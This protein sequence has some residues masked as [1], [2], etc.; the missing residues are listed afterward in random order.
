MF[1]VTTTLVGFLSKSG[2]PYSFDSL[3]TINVFFS[4]WVLLQILSASKTSMNC[5]RKSFQTRQTALPHVVGSNSATLA[6]LT[7]WQRS[8]VKNGLWILIGF[9]TWR[10][11]LMTTACSKLLW[12]SGF[13][14]HFLQLSV[15]IWVNP[16]L[17][18]FRSS[19]RTNWNSLTICST[20]WTSRL[21]QIPCL[22]FR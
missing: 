18:Y 22:I 14:M 16:L 15:P 1:C 17:L 12:R 9:K 11:M 5:G 7:C 2:Y 21:T 3:S 4:S 10:S 8:L 19:T 13:K 6:F 20:Y